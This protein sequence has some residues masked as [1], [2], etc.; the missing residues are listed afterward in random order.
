MSAPVF[1]YLYGALALAIVFCEMQIGGFAY[2]LA[3]KRSII[4]IGSYAL[5]LFASIVIY[6]TCFHRLRSFPGPLLARVSKFW[7][8]YHVRHSKNYELLHRLYAQYGPI[9]RT[10]Q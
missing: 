4:V 3:I 7:H 10:G 6:R 5:S 2:V 1:F 8:V 9:V